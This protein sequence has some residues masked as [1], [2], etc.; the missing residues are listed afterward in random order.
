MEVKPRDLGTRLQP[1]SG[2]QIPLSSAS[3]SLSLLQASAALA[4][5]TLG[6]SQWFRGVGGSPQWTEDRQGY[7]A[8]HPD[9]GLSSAVKDGTTDAGHSREG[10]K[11]VTSGHTCNPIDQSVQEGRLHRD[12]KQVGGGQ[13]LGTRRARS[14]H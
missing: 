11:P 6:Y 8:V 14:D 12:R 1:S 5:K 4:T 7:N 3:D 9:N 13:G 10:K 2:F